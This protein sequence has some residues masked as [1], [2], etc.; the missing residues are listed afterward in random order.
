MIVAVRLG[1]GLDVV[2]TV[3][4]RW[5]ARDGR[6]TRRSSAGWAGVER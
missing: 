4:S 1:A 5:L 3:S 2:S 6:A